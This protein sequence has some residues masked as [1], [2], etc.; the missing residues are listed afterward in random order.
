LDVSFARVLAQ[1]PESRLLRRLTVFQT[2]DPDT[3]ED[4][5]EEERPGP[6]LPGFDAAAA[7]DRPGLYPLRESPYL[8]NVRYL[9]LGLPVDE[10]SRHRFNSRLVMG[11]GAADA[12][13]RMTRV[14]ELHLFIRGLDSAKLFGLGTL[15][16]LRVLQVYHLLEYPLARLATNPALRQLTH[17][18]LHPAWLED[19][20][21]YRREEVRALLGSPHL[22]SL[23]HLQLRLSELGDRCCEDLVASG[24]LKRLEVLDL[25]HGTITDAGAR[26]LAAC[27]DLRH[28]DRLLIADN[29]LS[30][31]GVAAL[32]GTSIRVEAG[33]QHDIDDENWRYEGDME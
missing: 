30:G 10:T 20:S 14:E 9:H 6:T 13:E 33:A 26:T 17:L 32:R 11:M 28:L 12:I 24:I 18:L 7:E 1:T 22:V 16:H 15:Q 2:S 31:A 27:P 3:E 5:G 8:T 25:Q 19:P 4:E 29:N 21:A 23:R